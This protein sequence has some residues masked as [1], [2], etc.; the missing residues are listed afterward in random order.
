MDSPVVK[1][2]L[3]ILLLCAQIGV[4]SGVVRAEGTGRLGSVGIQVVPTATGELAVLQVPVGTPAAAAGIRPGDLIVRLDDHA[5]AG[6]DFA[7]VVSKYLWGAEGSRIVVHYLR[8]G[9]AGR[10]SAVLRRVAGEP[11]LTVS[12]AVHPVS[13]PTKRGEQR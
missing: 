4:W 9:E 12:P 8:P 6:S 13:D 11:R 2:V 1:M 10:K 3:V 7:A 5:L